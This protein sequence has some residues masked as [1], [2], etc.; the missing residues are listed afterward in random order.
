[1]TIEEFFIYLAVFSIATT[2]IEEIISNRKTKRELDK[3]DGLE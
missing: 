1:M 2:T 3:L